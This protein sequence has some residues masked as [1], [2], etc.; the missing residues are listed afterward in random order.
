M[1]SNKDLPPFLRLF[2]PA[3]KTVEQFQMIQSDEMWLN[4]QVRLSKKCYELLSKKLLFLA[5][6]SERLDEVQT[7]F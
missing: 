3:I 2:I 6:Q 5:K 4:Q 1:M 7:A